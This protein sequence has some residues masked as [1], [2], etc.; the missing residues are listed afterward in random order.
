MTRFDRYMLSQLA[1][2]FG[3]FAL[4]L[5]G[6]YWINTAVQVFDRLIGDGQS[7]GLVLRYSALSLPEVIGIVLPIA[8]FAAV[9]YVTNWLNGESEL[10]VLQSAGFSGWR[11]AR[12]VVLFG[13]AVSL[14]AALLVHVVLPSARGEM[15]D[16]KRSLARDV[17]ARLLSEGTFLHPVQGVTFYIRRIDDSGTLHDVFL[18]DRRAD[19]HAETYTAARA[20]LVN[21]AEPEADSGAQPRLVMLG[22][23][24]QSLDAESGRLL[25]TRFQDFSYDLTRL[26]DMGIGDETPVLALPTATLLRDPAA[27]AVLTGE[28]TGFVLAEGHGRVRDSLACLVT[29]LAGF[30][31]MLN[32]GFSRFAPWR[33]MGLAVVVLAL[34]KMTENITAAATLR[35]P[36]MWPAIYAPLVLGLAI[37]AA[38]LGW[39]GRRRAPAGGGARTA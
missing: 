36:A 28:T 3:F 24:A 29:A 18:S 13:L 32:A 21:T 38:F 12:P 16:M 25:T 22:G 14:G 9:V 4:V 20:Y 26:I 1:R 8:V 5:V 17:A 23:M 10:L 35:D 19:D 15:T 7:A 33:Q 34:V 30:A 39:T 2:L 31:V 6:I 27:I 11:L 37:T